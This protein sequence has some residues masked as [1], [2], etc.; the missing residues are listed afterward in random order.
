VWVESG[1]NADLSSEGWGERFDFYY[2]NIADWLQ[3]AN[4]PHPSGSWSDFIR[5]VNT[6]SR[7]KAAGFR[8]RYGTM[9]LINYWNE[10]KAKSWQTPGLWVCS[11]QPLGA[12]RNAADVLIDYIDEVEADDR[13]GLT[14]YTHNSS[15]GAFTEKGLTST[16]QDVKS[17]YRERQAAHYD[18]YTN[19]GAGIN[20]ARQEL[21]TNG[22]RDAVSMMVLMTDG[23]ANRPYG[24]ASGYAINEATL[25]RMSG[26]KIMTISLGLNADVELM[27]Q[28]A[29]ITGGKHFNVPGGGTVMQ[30]EEQLK[31]VF[32]EIAADRPLKLLPAGP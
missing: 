15:D 9:C 24:Y 3:L 20:K 6:S 23:V 2:S 5:Y 14:I 11:T 16:V 32:Q 22:R 31:T 18:A 29:D 17:C 10:K 12:A 27:Q 21:E 19:I 7:V 1:T 30:Y 8:Y 25:C 4:Y 13:V 26:I 28:I